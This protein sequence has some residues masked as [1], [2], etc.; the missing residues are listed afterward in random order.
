[1]SGRAHIT[2]VDDEECVGFPQAGGGSP[3]EREGRPP[4]QGGRQGPT[5]ATTDA[6]HEEKQPDFSLDHEVHI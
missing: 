4:W 5:I 6:V 3:S 1:M 2:D